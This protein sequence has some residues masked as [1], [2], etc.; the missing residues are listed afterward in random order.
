MPLAIPLLAGPSALATLLLLQS[1]TTATTPALMVAVTV[2]WACSAV[3]L[4]MLAVQ[5]L[6]NGVRTS[7]AFR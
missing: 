2:A 3:L 4:L 1:D 5:M 6:L 7:L